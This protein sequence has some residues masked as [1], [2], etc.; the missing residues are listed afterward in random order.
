MTSVLCPCPSETLKPFGWHV[1]SVLCHCL[2]SNSFHGINRS[3]LPLKSFLRRFK[4]FCVY[5][6]TLSPKIAYTTSQGLIWAILIFSTTKK[7]T[8]QPQNPIF[9]ESGVFTAHSWRQSH[10]RHKDMSFELS[11]SSRPTQMRSTPPTISLRR[12]ENIISHS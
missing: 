2:L 7:E 10:T 11:V 4:D 9:G 1:P 6:Y 12:L 5:F 3:Y 8:L